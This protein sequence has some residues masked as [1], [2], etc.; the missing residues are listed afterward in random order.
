MLVL[1]KGVLEILVN[2]VFIIILVMMADVLM[3]FTLGKRG[4]DSL[5]FSHYKQ[6]MR[7]P[8]Y[9]FFLVQKI[10]ICLVLVTFISAIRKMLR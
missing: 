10:M 5:N 2:A 7:M 6:A 3:F 1:L 4:G 8:V 9:R